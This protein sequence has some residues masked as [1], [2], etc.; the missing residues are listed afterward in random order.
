MTAC[1]VTVSVVSVRAGSDVEHVPSQRET[2][3]S[4]PSVPRT[5]IHTSLSSSTSNALLT[6]D[7]R[8]INHDDGRRH[9]PGHAHSRSFPDFSQPSKAAERPSGRERGRRC[10]EQDGEHRQEHHDTKS[11]GSPGPRSRSG[12]TSHTT[13]GQSSKRQRD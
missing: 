11:G 13:Q 4:M 5:E 12:A 8:A 2:V 10:D 3:T 9:H 1:F 7:R 6:S